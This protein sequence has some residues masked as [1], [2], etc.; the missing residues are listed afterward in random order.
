MLGLGPNGFD[1]HAQT[2]RVTSLKARF[3]VSLFGTFGYASGPVL[4]I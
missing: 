4:K 2:Q 3:L 1:L